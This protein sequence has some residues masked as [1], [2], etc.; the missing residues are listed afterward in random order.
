MPPYG[1]ELSELLAPHVV[2]IGGILFREEQEQKAQV[3]KKVR[4]GICDAQFLLLI[5]LFVSCPFWECGTWCLLRLPNNCQ[6]CLFLLLSLFCLF[7]TIY[8]FSVLPFRL[9]R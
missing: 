1:R 8:C 9:Q 2:N 3:I 6:Y 4:T 7:L 5:I